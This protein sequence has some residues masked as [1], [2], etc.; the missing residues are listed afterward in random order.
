MERMTLIRPSRCA[1]DLRSARKGF[2]VERRE[3]ADLQR[4]YRVALVLLLKRLWRKVPVRAVRPGPS[5]GCCSRCLPLSA[6]AAPATLGP[7]RTRA[8]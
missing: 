3:S 5:P 8:A 4:T 1:K 7:S 6:A 2:P